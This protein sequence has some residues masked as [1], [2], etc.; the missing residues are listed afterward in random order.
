MSASATSPDASVPSILDRL[1]GFFGALRVR[2]LAVGVGAEVDL[3]RAL[4]HVDVLDREGV[5]DACRTTL[6]KSPADLAILDV[7]FDE[8]WSSP[9]SAAEPPG[10]VQ[11]P[12]APERPPADGRPVAPA[13][14]ALPSTAARPTIAVRF[15]VYSPEA[16]PAG[17][18]LRPL[19]ARQ[20][21]ALRSGARRFRRSVA[22]W[23]GR[24]Y[25]PAPRGIV[26]FRRTA[27]RAVRLEGEWLEQEWKRRRQHRAELVVLWDVS[28]SMRDHDDRLAGLVY[29]LHRVVRRSRVFAFSTDLVEVTGLLAGR[30]YPRALTAI[31]RFLGPAG[32]GT[33][34]GACLAEFRRRSGWLVH[35]RTTVLVVSDGWDLGPGNLVSQEIRW[36]RSRARL[37][38]WVNPYARDPG[39]RPTTAAMREAL[40]HIDL[41][42]GPADFERAGRFPAARLRG[43]RVAARSLATVANG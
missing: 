41:L 32:G 28:G 2:G 23:P 17:H 24:R 20:L 16:P 14:P 42:L 5:R 3:G 27:R 25:G 29:A 37:L 21:A 22:T 26:D 35:R 18:P 39:F 11:R 34:L 43:L 40:P 31:G 13:P 9:A 4:R 15:G 1:A 12:V 7:A 6:A 36:L 10:V 19:P 30:P 33:R 38:A 8:Y